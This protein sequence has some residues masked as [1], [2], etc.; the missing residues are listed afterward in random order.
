MLHLVVDSYHVGVHL[1]DLITES[2][3]LLVL[4]LE[5]IFHVLCLILGRL[6]NIDDFTKCLVLLFD[7]IFLDLDDALIVIFYV[8]DNLLKKLNSLHCKQ[9][10]LQHDVNQIWSS[11]LMT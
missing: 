7:L 9:L 3:E 1:F 5:L 4:H 6:D 2:V 8:Y 10:H 11:P